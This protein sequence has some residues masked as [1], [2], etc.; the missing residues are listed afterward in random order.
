MRGGGEKRGGV[1]WEDGEPFHKHHTEALEKL[2][3]FFF[4]AITISLVLPRLF[5]VYSVPSLCSVLVD[6]GGGSGGGGVCVRQDLIIQSWLTRNSLC[7]S[8]S[9]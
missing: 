2:V 4:S 6:G 9:P 3:V 5:Y 7:R 1:G 8:G